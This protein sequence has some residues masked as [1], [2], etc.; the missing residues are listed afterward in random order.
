MK[1]RIIHNRIRCVHCG[2]VIESEYTHDFKMC[3]CGRVFVD[4]G[5]AY[6]RR[7]FTEKGDFE[8]L[9]EVQTINEQYN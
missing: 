2:D 6:L 5:H 7:G 1:N 8:D 3:C 9:S 4:G